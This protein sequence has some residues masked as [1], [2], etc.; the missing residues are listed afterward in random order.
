MLREWEGILRDANRVGPLSAPVVIAEFA[1]FECPAC[2][3]AYPRLDS[4]RRQDSTRIAVAFVHYPLVRIHPNAFRA[5][6]LAECGA[7]QGRFPAMYD[8][9]FRGARVLGTRTTQEWASEAGIPNAAGFDDCM[10]SEAGRE[11]IERHLAMAQSLHL[12]GTPAFAVNGVL[13]PVGTPFQVIA[14][15]AKAALSR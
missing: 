14:D 12:E 7:M 6:L 15:S 2:Q 3:R 1:D 10:R 13:F 8:A 5:S 11:R 4:L 9:L